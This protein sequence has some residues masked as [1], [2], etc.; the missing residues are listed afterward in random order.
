M[1]IACKRCALARRRIAR[2]AGQERRPPSPMA[3][4]IST[5]PDV[6]QTQ[7]V[8][9]CCCCHSSFV[10]TPI[11]G[12][13]YLQQYAPPRV[14][15]RRVL[16]WSDGGKECRRATKVPHA[17]RES[18]NLYFA[19]KLRRKARLGARN[20]MSRVDWYSMQPNLSDQLVSNA[21]PPSRGPLT[22]AYN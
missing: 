6:A 11:S 16:Q 17:S 12:S 2:H 9:S 5:R 19:A 13:S 3:A 1:P 18:S 4:A 14:C 21:T 20:I 15:F 10:T 8:R 7:N 22:H